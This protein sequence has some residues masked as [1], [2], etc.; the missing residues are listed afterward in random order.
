M[1]SVSALSVGA[2]TTTFFVRAS[3]Y[4]ERWWGTTPTRIIGWADFTLS[5]G[6]Y[7]RKWPLPLY[8]LCGCLYACPYTYENWSSLE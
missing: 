8:L 7:A 6:M 1:G 3:R 4:S 2:Y 5:D